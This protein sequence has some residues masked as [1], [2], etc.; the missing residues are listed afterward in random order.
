MTFDIG[1]AEPPELVD[2]PPEV[3]RLVHAV[4]RMRDGWAEGDDARKTWLQRETYRACDAV[5]ARLDDQPVNS[6]TV[7]AP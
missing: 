7:H 1:V 3:R 2:L 4:D 5:W 6:S